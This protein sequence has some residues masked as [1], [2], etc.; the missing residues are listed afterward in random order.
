MKGQ[1][2]FISELSFF[3]FPP[4]EAGNI[5]HSVCMRGASFFP[6][7][8]VVLLRADSRPRVQV[9]DFSTSR[10]GKQQKA[11]A[12]SGILPHH[13]PAK[14]ALSC[15]SP[16]SSVSCCCPPLCELKLSPFRSGVFLQFRGRRP[17]LYI[18]TGF[19]SPRSV[20][21]LNWRSFLFLDHSIAQK[22]SQNCHTGKKQYFLF[23][24]QQGDHNDS[25]CQS[26][27]MHPDFPPTVHLPSSSLP[28]LLWSSALPAGTGW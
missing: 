16:F 28:A 9:S 4:P 7:R 27:F 23:T 25:I 14:S 26:L 21:D 24:G 2:R 19:P 15:F 6:A 17:R 13:G 1:L 3:R 18:E 11:A 20:K 12:R 22:L 5:D 10:G 8:A